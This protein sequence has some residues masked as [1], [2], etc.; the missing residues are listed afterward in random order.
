M[1]SRPQNG[2]DPTGPSSAKAARA[3]P[4]VNITTGTE[5]FALQQQMPEGEAVAEIHKKKKHRAGKKR[6]NRRQSF[7]A[8]SDQTDDTD[9]QAQRP[10]LRI[11]PESS[12]SQSAFYRLGAHG[13]R[14]N[15]S[16]DSEALL[17]HR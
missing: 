14:S 13:G 10:G 5:D 4:A 6:R 8:P 9:T 17:D 1:S 2:F 12:A 11:V 16:L 15:T 7:A 3:S